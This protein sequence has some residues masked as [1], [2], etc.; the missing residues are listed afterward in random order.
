MWLAAFDTVHINSIYLEDGNTKKR[1]F[2]FLPDG[3]GV[4]NDKTENNSTDSIGTTIFLKNAFEKYQ[5]ICPKKL[6]SIAEF[7]IEEFL[8]YFIGPSCPKIV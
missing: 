3:A 2:D 5:K 1:T 4:F 8:E 7:I 6:T